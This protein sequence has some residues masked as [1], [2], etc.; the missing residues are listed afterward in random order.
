MPDQ[1]GDEVIVMTLLEATAS[2][3][4]KAEIELK[5]VWQTGLRRSVNANTMLSPMI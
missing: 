1:G 5:S 4:Q 2:G 3:G